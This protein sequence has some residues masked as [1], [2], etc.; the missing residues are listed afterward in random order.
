MGKYNKASIDRVLAL[1]EIG[2]DEFIPGD[3]GLGEDRVV[4][5]KIIEGIHG[6]V[7]VAVSK[8]LWENSTQVTAGRLL[9]GVIENPIKTKRD[10]DGLFELAGKKLNADLESFRD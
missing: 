10:L 5:E 2:F 4:A 1:L 9:L 3:E 7:T 8:L 6:H